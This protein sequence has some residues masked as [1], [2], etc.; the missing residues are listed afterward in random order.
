LNENKY[1]IEN[2][3]FNLI[4]LNDQ[5]WRDFLKKLLDN[6]PQNAITNQAL[7][8]KELEWIDANCC[9]P[10]CGQEYSGRPGYS[11]I[12][13]GQDGKIALRA[14]AAEF[15]VRS[16]LADPSQYYVNNSLSETL[17]LFKEWWD[18]IPP[19]PKA[20]K[21]IVINKEEDDF[22]PLHLYAWLLTKI[23]QE[24]PT[25]AQRKY[26]F[27]LK[28]W[29]SALEICMEWIDQGMATKTNNDGI[30]AKI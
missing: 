17:R 30:L 13:C 1:T 18:K 14:W 21:S 10:I 4:D 16:S 15:G 29:S 26:F 28:P 5:E 25:H 6:P 2:K 20:V 12:I 8:K 3:E 9:L 27:H 23:E 24:E 7:T 22:R 19:G 11:S